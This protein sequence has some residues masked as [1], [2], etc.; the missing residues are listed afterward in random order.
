[1]DQ[2][3]HILQEIKATMHIANGIKPN[4]FRPFRVL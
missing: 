4:A 2:T 1:M 3:M